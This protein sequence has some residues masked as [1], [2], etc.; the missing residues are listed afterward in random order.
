MGEIVRVKHSEHG[1]CQVEILICT[2]GVP[3][4]FL[5]LF[6]FLTN[7]T[8]LFSVQGCSIYIVIRF[9]LIRVNFVVVIVNVNIAAKVPSK[10]DASQQKVQF[11]TFQLLPHT[12][13]LWGITIKTLVSR[14][15]ITQKNFELDF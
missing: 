3:V 8:V 4:C 6:R 7:E 5:F 14:Y 15:Y 1:S 11:L 9:H 2:G 12:K 10:F 13:I